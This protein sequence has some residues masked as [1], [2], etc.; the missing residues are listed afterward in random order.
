MEQLRTRDHGQFR[1]LGDFSGMPLL[2]YVL[3]R[4]AARERHCQ[5]VTGVGQFIGVD[6]CARFDLDGV[7]GAYVEKLSE[8]FA[9]RDPVAGYGEIADLS[10][11]SA[12]GVP[13]DAVSQGLVVESFDE[14]YLIIVSEA[15][16]T[17]QSDGLTVDTVVPVRLQVF[18][19][20]TVMTLRHDVRAAVLPADVPHASQADHC[21]TQSEYGDRAVAVAPSRFSPGRRRHMRL[22]S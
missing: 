7:A 19:D 15:F 17:H 3:Q 18:I 14:R 12:V 6:V 8:R 16:D 11:F 22:V 20:L 1:V 5:A 13:D 10:C 4:L 9:V 21:E 2:G